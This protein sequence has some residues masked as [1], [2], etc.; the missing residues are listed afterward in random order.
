MVKKRYWS[1]RQTFYIRYQ[2]HS[3]PEGQAGLFSIKEKSVFMVIVAIISSDY[4]MATFRR[5]TEKVEFLGHHLPI[6]SRGRER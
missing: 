5:Q 1:E 6:V 3:L 4:I 2:R